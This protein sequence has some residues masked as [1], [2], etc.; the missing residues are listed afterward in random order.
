M[1]IYK[2]ISPVNVTTYR[3]RVQVGD[4]DNGLDEA[5]R[6]IA[7]S[8]GCNTPSTCCEIVLEGNA[9]YKLNRRHELKCALT[10]RGIGSNRPA[11]VIQETALSPV[12]A[13]NDSIIA[14]KSA[15]LSERMRFEL[16]G[17][18]VRTASTKKYHDSK[19]SYVFKIYNAD[20]VV[21]RDVDF[22]LENGDYTNFD[23]R[24]CSGIEISGCRLTNYNADTFSAAVPVGGVLWFRGETSGVRI[25]GNTLS[26]HGNDE[27]IAFFGDSKAKETDKAG[28]TSASAPADA[29]VR[30]DISIIGNRF[31]YGGGFNKTL[32]ID[33]LMNFA[34]ASDSDEVPVIYRD[35]TVSDNKFELKDLVRRVI[36]VLDVSKV[37]A[38]SNFRIESNSIAH[39]YSVPE[40]AASVCDLCL[41]ST[42][43]MADG[44]LPEAIEFS[45]N[46]ITA[47]ETIGAG[48]NGHIAI[49]LDGGNVNATGNLFDGTGF[50]YHTQDAG[51]AS[52]IIP[53]A[54]SKT[55]ASLNMSGNTIRNTSLAGIIEKANA[56]AVFNV[57]M[58]DNTITGVS[59]VYVR[60]IGTAAIHL[61]QENNF[62]RTS[63]FELLAQGFAMKGSIW[64]TG[65][66]WDT[67]AISGSE[68]ATVFHDYASTPILYAL[69]YTIF[70][71]NV[72]TGSR[73]ADK[74]NLPS[75]GC[76]VTDGNRLN[77]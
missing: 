6:M 3:V 36:T 55:G 34:Y 51:G 11:I 58:R 39:D 63:S 72:I 75:S 76:R 56:G 27:I 22:H 31:V 46:T 30:Q 1:A 74:I 60:E 2:S 5:M 12:G 24:S 13:V 41:L 73:K 20:H 37:S 38:F 69:D 33:I 15:N 29:V 25:V 53:F 40:E 66:I 44:R 7:E 16:I 54:L 71:N 26:K 52:G 8:P 43:T 47:S 14:I 9:S 57:A 45:R 4:L 65:N 42:K 18:K 35:V 32:P 21:V 48:G 10:I 61:R 70:R 67:T 19:A 64:A 59:K 28:N 50:R 49:W 23:F 62:F 68:W 77:M 17:V